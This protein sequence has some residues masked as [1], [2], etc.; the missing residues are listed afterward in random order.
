MKLVFNEVM[1]CLKNEIVTCS[2]YS[3]GWCFS[4]LCVYFIFFQNETLDSNQYFKVFTNSHLIVL[5][6]IYGLKYNMNKSYFICLEFVDWRLNHRQYKITIAET[7]PSHISAIAFKIHMLLV[8]YV[9]SQ[10]IIDNKNLLCS[11]WI[12]NFSILKWW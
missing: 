11:I 9:W 10:I 5:S 4:L 2:M 6:G 3:M 8:V 1:F 12:R 7:Y